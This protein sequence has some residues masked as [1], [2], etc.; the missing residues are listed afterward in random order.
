MP[1]KKL[2]SIITPD[3]GDFLGFAGILLIF[4]GVGVFLGF[5]LAVLSVYHKFLQI[6]NEKRKQLY[7]DN[8]D[9]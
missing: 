9:K 6:R 1:F 4:K 7:D 2:F 5:V 3:W 8:F